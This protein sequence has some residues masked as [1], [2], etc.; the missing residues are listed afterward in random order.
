MTDTLNSLE[1]WYTMAESEAER[2]SDDELELVVEELRRLGRVVIPCECGADGCRGLRV[3]T[4]E[5]ADEIDG[6]SDG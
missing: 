6:E 5:D 1:A 4:P 2:L 3:V